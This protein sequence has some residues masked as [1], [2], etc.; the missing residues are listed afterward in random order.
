MK[1]SLT[2]PVV[3]VTTVQPLLLVWVC[4][5]C[6]FLAIALAAVLSPGRRW[7]EI[8]GLFVLGFVAL[9]VL[10]VGATS[11]VL[12]LTLIDLEVISLRNLGSPTFE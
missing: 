4:A 6:F 9:S 2:S 10:G 8:L 12:D 7:F 11:Y 1:S 3:F 5:I